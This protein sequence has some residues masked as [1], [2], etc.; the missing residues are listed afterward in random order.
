MTPDVA[1]TASLT[2]A[3][4]SVPAPPGTYRLQA[5]RSLTV[6]VPR[7]AAAVGAV[8]TVACVLLAAVALGVGSSSQ[9]YAD[10]LEV[11]RGGGSRVDRLVVLGWRLPRTVL[12][13]TVGAALGV[14]GAI[15][16]ELTRNPLGSPDLIGFTT[17]AQTGIL[18]TVL[19][20]GGALSVGPAALVGG[21][22]V[23][24]LV[25]TLAARGGFGG[26]HLVLIGIAVTAMLGSFNRWLLLRTDAASAYGAAK[27]VT[28][29]LA[30]ADARVATW[31]VLATCIVGA[32]TL[33]HSR[34]LR[35]LDLGHDLATALGTSLRR[36]RGTLVLLG[37][38][39]VAIATTAAG[40]IAFVALAAP[41][42]ARLMT[43]APSAPLLVSGTTGALMLLA[44]DVTAQTLLDG[45]PV[46]V[47]TA[48][49]GGLYLLL[50]LVSD[51]RTRTA[52]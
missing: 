41:H 43:R 44:A 35:S 30:A 39:L 34:D 51:S 52:P 16:Q 1:P 37:A 15:F 38:A 26:L 31:A 8:L 36:A 3:A 25:H 19:L 17:G 4:A 2:R 10:V 14:S 7:R 23:A 45:L 24:L 42:A 47:V 49:T 13:L 33:L 27:A 11:L 12:A 22:T 9:S 20:G 48:S 5:G 28:G 29:S 46:G 50:L 40:P 6:L 32:L 18:V 21:A